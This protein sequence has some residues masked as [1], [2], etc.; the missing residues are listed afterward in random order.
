MGREDLIIMNNPLIMGSSVVRGELVAIVPYCLKTNIIFGRLYLKK[1]E[2]NKMTTF[3]EIGKQWTKD[4]EAR[5]IK[6]FDSA[7]WEDLP[8][9]DAPFAQGMALKGVINEWH[10]SAKRVS[11]YS[12]FDSF[13][14][15]GVETKK[16][17]IFFLDDGL[18]MTPLALRDKE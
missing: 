7:K 15:Y 17:Q 4:N 11:M 2:S 12:G 6:M 8:I 18:S 13:G 1:K 3:T 9:K 5:F 10:I 16:Q 14:V